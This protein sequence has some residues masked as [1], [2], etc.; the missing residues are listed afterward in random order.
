MEEI[1]ICEENLDSEE[2]KRARDLVLKY[3]HIFSKNDSDIGPNMESESDDS[4][5]DEKNINV[6]VSIN[7]E[8]HDVQENVVSGVNSDDNDAEA[9]SRIHLVD[10]GSTAATGD[11]QEAACTGEPEGGED[12]LH[13]D[14][15]SDLPESNISNGSDNRVSDT[16]D[17]KSAPIHLTNVYMENCSNISVGGRLTVNQEE[18]ITSKNTDSSRRATYADVTRKTNVGEK[19]QTT[20][21]SGESELQ[22]GDRSAGTSEDNH[23][24]IK[25]TEV[26]DNFESGHFILIGGRVNLSKNVRPMTKTIES[27][28]LIPWLAIYD[29][30][31]ES[32][33]DG[34]LSILEEPLRRTRSFNICAIQD[35]PK[36]TE[37]NTCWCF[38]TRTSDDSRKWYKEVQSSLSSH[39]QGIVKFVQSYTTLTVVVLWPENESEVTYIRKIIDKLEENVEPPPR[40]CVCFAS[41]NPERERACALIVDQFAGYQTDSTIRRE[42][43]IWL[44]EELDVLYLEDK[45]EVDVEQ[46]HEEVETFYRGGSLPWSV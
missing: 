46:L 33:D 38:D 20:N 23:E 22:K 21:V 19:T 1:D 32:R 14:D 2:L 4:A 42:D 40:F 29:T 3:K 13:S 17:T 8:F 41:R 15:E 24:K 45:S 11:G 10:S 5:S 9:S 31:V 37:K 18:S 39:L 7:S 12:A 44:N 43:A 25:F 35:K 27:L 30:D 36:V 6:E 34:L 28:A 26:V 16:G